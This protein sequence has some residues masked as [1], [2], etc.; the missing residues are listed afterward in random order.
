MTETKNYKNFDE[1][2]SREISRL[3]KEKMA[4]DKSY[5]KASAVIERDLAE[6]N[7]KVYVNGTHIVTV[8]NEEL[9]ENDVNE[10]AERIAN[11]VVSK[12]EKKSTKNNIKIFIIF[13]IV[14]C[15]IV[16][17]WKLLGLLL[18][19]HCSELDMADSVIAFVFSVLVTSIIV[20]K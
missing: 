3:F 13:N 4:N 14:N 19:G 5:P 2:L 7:V 16:I 18:L 9:D 20:N 15:V 17:I 10:L 12:F 11:N 1:A 6:G 8:E